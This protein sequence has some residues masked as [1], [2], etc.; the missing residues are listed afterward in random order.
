[1]R[2]VRTTGLSTE[3][4]DHHGL[5]AAVCLDLGISEKINR[6]IG[7]KDPRQRPSLGWLPL[8]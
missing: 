8:R 1:M 3:V 6:R 5:V 2:L 7:S 4:I